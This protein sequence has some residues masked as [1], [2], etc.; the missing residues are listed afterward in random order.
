MTMKLDSR[1]ERL[2]LTYSLLMTTKRHL[3]AGVNSSQ[4]KFDG[5]AE[6]VQRLI[7]SM[8]KAHD[9]ARANIREAQSIQKRDYDMKLREETYQ[10]GDLVYRLN[11][12][13]KV[14]E[15][16]KLKDI[17]S[18]PYVVVKILTPVVTQVQKRDKVLNL[19]NNNLKRCRDRHVPVWAQRLRDKLLTGDVDVFD[20]DLH[21]DKLFVEKDR[22]RPVEK[23]GN[24]L[25]NVEVNSDPPVKPVSILSK[26]NLKSLTP[27][28]VAVP[29]KV[30][31]S[32]K[33]VPKK[34]SFKEVEQTTISGR[35]SRRPRY[36][37]E[38]H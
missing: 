4:E 13:S 24:S 30:N 27:K 29:K 37:D 2:R 14:G 31:K 19:H 17:Y 3:L 38:Y 10:V 15:S 25:V 9:L 16:N 34:V 5:H 6:F 33:S 12:K 7:R 28:S 26:E 32:A 11:L 35:K 23:K 20:E 36:L 22:R 18:G 8:E 21:L 1:D